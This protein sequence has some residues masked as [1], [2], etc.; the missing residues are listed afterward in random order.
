MTDDQK[1]EETKKKPPLFWVKVILSFLG[2]GLFFVL[3]A[4]IFMFLI[5]VEAD[6]SFLEVF[7][8]MLKGLVIILVVFIVIWIFWEGK[9]SNR[10][11]AMIKNDN[12]VLYSIEF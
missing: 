9:V 4:S 8:E 12:A 1:T 11:L 5:R 2:T 6:I 7:W 3:V 10:Y